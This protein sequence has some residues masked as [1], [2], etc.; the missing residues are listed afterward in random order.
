MQYLLLIALLV[1]ACY[2]TNRNLL[3]RYWVGGRTKL[4]KIES[5]N[6]V[7]SLQVFKNKNAELLIASNVAV[8]IKDTGS[9]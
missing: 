1:S 7:L 2:K 4:Y 8:S 3:G 5:I 6:T 9:P